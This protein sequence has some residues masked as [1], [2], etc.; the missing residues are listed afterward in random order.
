MSLCRRPVLLVLL[1]VVL[2]A[3]ADEPA[4]AP[5]KKGDRIVFL[6][7]LIT[8]AG[9]DNPMGYVSLIRRKFKEAGIEVIGAG[10]SGNKVPDLQKRLE[11]DVL[12]RKPALVVIYI[13]I[14]DVWH[15]EK[16]PKRG[17][18]R[19]KYEVGLEDVISRITATGSRVLLCT[20]TV[21]GEKPD[22]T[23]KNDPKLD[24]YAGISRA[25]AKKLK[26]PVCDLRKGFIDFLKTSN[27]KGRE[28]GLLT[29]DGVHLNPTGDDLVAHM[30]LDCLEK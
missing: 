13:G 7:D 29:T 11:R 26:V 24:E 2:P 21:I 9:N 30:I 12:S 16:D 6:G 17:T 22:G 18:P 20:P 1:T 28:N 25:V 10:V 15:G 27:P 19:D 8:Q 5:L 23:N 3:G 4:A 14:N